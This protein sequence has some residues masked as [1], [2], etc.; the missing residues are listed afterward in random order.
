MYR[1]ACLF[2]I[3]FLYYYHCDLLVFL[4]FVNHKLLRGLGESRALVVTVVSNILHH[5]G[6]VFELGRLLTLLANGDKMEWNG[7]EWNE[8]NYR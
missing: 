6:L 2:H 3:C 1:T 4:L 8:I 7:M 5:S